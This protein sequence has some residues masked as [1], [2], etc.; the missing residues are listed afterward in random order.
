MI[1]SNRKLIF[2]AS[3][4]VW[5]LQV[6]VTDAF[7]NAKIGGSASRFHVAGVLKQEKYLWRVQD[8]AVSKIGG[9]IKQASRLKSSL[10]YDDCAIMEG[11]SPKAIKLRQQL[12]SIW[13]DPGSDSPIILCGPKGS[14]KGELAEEIVSRL[15]SWQTQ[16]VH[17][18]SLDDGL[19]FIDTI[20]GTS[21]H[22]GLFD[23][24]STQANTTLILKGF[25]TLHVDSKE[26]YDKRQELVHTLAGLLNQKYYSKYHNQTK[27]FL[28]RIVGCTQ[29]DPDYFKKVLSE[30]ATV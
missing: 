18:L 30:G 17:R 10:E 28:P 26:S 16:K 24:L 6:P 21:E 1:L 13:N 15:P 8:C 11:T 12:Q 4:S 2:V 7:S 27:P 25:Q 19:D 20:L 9:N 5:S 3:L 23:D 29:R 14:G 22:P